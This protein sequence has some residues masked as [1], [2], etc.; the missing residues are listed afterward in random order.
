M[1]N[2]VDKAMETADYKTRQHTTGMRYDVDTAANGTVSGE[3]VGTRGLYDHCPSMNTLHNRLAPTPGGVLHVMTVWSV[4]TAQPHVMKSRD[5][6]KE[7]GRPSVTFSKLSRSVC[8]PKFVPVMTMRSPP[9]VINSFAGTCGCT[10]VTVGDAYDETKVL[11][12]E[13][14]HAPASPEPMTRH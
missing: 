13:G 10:A 9:S 2:C 8:G 6:F 3:D 11:L 5:E 4:V 1:R 12:M 14:Y 7:V